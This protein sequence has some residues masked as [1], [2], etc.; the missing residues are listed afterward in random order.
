MLDRSAKIDVP[1]AVRSAIADMRTLAQEAKRTRQLGRLRHLMS[2][3][4][5]AL[6]AAS[7]KSVAQ[8]SASKQQKLLDRILALNAA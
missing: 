6:Y 4:G 1:Q 8:M 5:K 7:L 2:P 3:K